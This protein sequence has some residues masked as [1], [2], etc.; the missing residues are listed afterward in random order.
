MRFAAIFI[1]CG[2]L[3]A[4][5]AFAYSKPGAYFQESEEYECLLTGTGA[6]E[7]PYEEAFQFLLI[8]EPGYLHFVFSHS[9]APDQE[10]V[11]AEYQAQHDL[12]WSVCYLKIDGHIW[13]V[14]TTSVTG[15]PQEQA[16]VFLG[17]LRHLSFIRTLSP[18]GAQEQ[19][20]R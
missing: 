16:Q 6:I 19:A 5:N 12:I 13:S 1:V 9:L 15:L 20:V 7:P 11:L 2:L 8:H 17:H 18:F 14:V 4:S 3:L 10:G